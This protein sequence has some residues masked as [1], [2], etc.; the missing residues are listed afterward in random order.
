MVPV[1]MTPGSSR[2][3]AMR[4]PLFP[5]GKG[6]VV[7]SHKHSAE[8]PITHQFRGNKGRVGV[9]LKAKVNWLHCSPGSPFIAAAGQENAVLWQRFSM[10]ATDPDHHSPMSR[11]A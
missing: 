9:C 1:L 7:S 2:V 8:T 11:R 10:A 6:P 3:T 5:L 4:H